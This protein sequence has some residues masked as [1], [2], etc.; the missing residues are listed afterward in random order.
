MVAGNVNWSNY[1]GEQYGGSLKILKL[2]LTHDPAISL[3]SIFPEKAI[4]QKDTCTHSI[5]VLFTAGQLKK[6]KK[7]FSHVLLFATPWTTQ[8][9]EF[10]RLEY[11]SR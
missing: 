11:W 6:K 1:H 4:I 9:M 5:A 8:S 7:F 3:P 10:S 2:E